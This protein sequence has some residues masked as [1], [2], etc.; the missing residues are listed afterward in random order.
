[1][2]KRSSIRIRTLLVAAALIFGLA[3]SPAHALTQHDW[4]V[5]LVDAL[6][7]SFGLPDT[8]VPE[9]YLNILSGKR[10]LRFEAEETGSPDDSVSKMALPNFGPFSGK[11]WLLGISRPTDVHLTLTVPLDGNYRIAVALRSPGHIVK[12]AGQTFQADGPAGKFELVDLGEVALTA[13]PVLMVITLPAGGA[14][15]FVTLTAPD[16]PPIAP[17]RGWQPTEPL[18]W[19]V[20]A[21]TMVQT[22][23]LAEQ[24]PLSAEPLPAI[25]AEIL[26]E[27]GGARLVEDTHLGAPSA[28]RWLRT[29]V[30]AATVQVPLTM[31]EG[32]FV[33]LTLTAMGGP[34]TVRVNQHLE[35]TVT[36]K[37][38]LDE[39]M[40]P[41]IYL[42]GGENQLTITLPPRSGLDRIRI[43][44][45][46]S[47]L[48]ALAEALQLTVP[49]EP[50]TPADLDRLYPRLAT[51]PR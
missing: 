22:L 23:H 36:A 21:T 30:Q 44:P 15:D 46:Q 25:E 50:P 42:P 27:T 20:L 35:L 5:T 32:G 29:S 19:E 43:W 12:I 17:D 16:L 41:P 45:R 26:Q 14:L 7:R 1:M 3:P 48:A 13:G 47:G 51:A 11:G 28:G 33:D 38:F 8:P 39:V 4:M 40:V 37:A 6:G 34:I 2:R 24:L 10:N 49:E 9:D 31:A 18:T